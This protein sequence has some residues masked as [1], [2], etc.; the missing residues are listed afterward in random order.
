MLDFFDRIFGRDGSANRGSGKVAKDRLQFVLV[1][2]RIKLPPDQ[3]QA[4]KREILEV[5]SKYVRVDLDN[6]DFALSNRERTGLLI[7]EIPFIEIQEE[8]LNTDDDPADLS[9]ESEGDADRHP[10]PPATPP[11]SD[12]SDSVSE[13]TAN[14]DDPGKP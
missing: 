4:M 12:S 2:D 14:D 10:Q 3:M 13:T 11:E 5:I 8:A 6:V 9:G 1:Q 7:A